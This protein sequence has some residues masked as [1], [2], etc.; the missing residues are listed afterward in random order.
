[1]FLHILQDTLYKGHIKVITSFDD[2][3][4]NNLELVSISNYFNVK[5]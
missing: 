4:D 5:M 1:M 2:V 3:L